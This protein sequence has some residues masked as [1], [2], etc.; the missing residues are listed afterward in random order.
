MR[1]IKV[2][3][4]LLFVFIPFLLLGQD[5]YRIT[6]DLTYQIDS[7]SMASIQTERMYLDFSKDISVFKSYTTHMRD[8]ILESSNPHA[9]L[10]V[11]KSEFIY[12]IYKT[13]EQLISLFD[14]TAYK[15]ELEEVLPSFEWKMHSETKTILGYTCSLA[16]TTFKGREYTAWYTLE[17]PISEG[18]YKFHGLPG[19]IMEIYDTKNHYHFE[20]K[21]IEKL[22][23]NIHIENQD[24][25][26]ISHKDYEVFLKKI[27]E[28]PSLV[29]YNPGIQ[30]P[31]EGLDKY[32]RNHRERNKS[33][34]NPIEL[35]HN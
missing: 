15:Y 24:Y 7:T 2:L 3:F 32:D 11:P 12:K 27:K 28:K 10:G 4:W 29:L 9:L 20:A 33:K 1:N 34:N 8:S 35:I 31:K 22:R 13:K 25:T 17:V 6:Y 5:T 18:P 30:L 23:S 21:G 16:T 19:M 14:Y 26:K